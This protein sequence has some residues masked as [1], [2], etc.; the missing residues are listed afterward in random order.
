MPR[1]LDQRGYEHTVL[2]STIL[3]HISRCTRE[4]RDMRQNGRWGPI[5]Q[6]GRG[7][8]CRVVPKQQTRATLD[9]TG[10]SK[11]VHMV[12]KNTEIVQLLTGHCAATDCERPGSRPCRGE[13]PNLGCAKCNH[14]FA[15]FRSGTVS[16]GV[17]IYDL[18]KPGGSTAQPILALRARSSVNSVAWSPNGHLLAGGC[19]SG[20][21]YLWDIRR[22]TKEWSTLKDQEK[23][24]VQ[25]SCLTVT[26]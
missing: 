12:N 19:E 8:P 5:V 10:T 3:V 13:S 24:P 25:V 11:L 22:P 15:S 26:K 20:I 23:N 1:D 9:G 17:R 18:R 14:R 4:F 16:N 2:S 6:L 21:V 7:R